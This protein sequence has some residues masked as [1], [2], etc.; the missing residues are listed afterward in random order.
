MMR[1]LF[2]SLSSVILLVSCE[3]SDNLTPTTI[4]NIEDVRNTEFSILAFKTGEVSA[5]NPVVHGNLLPTRYSN[6]AG[7]KI[8]STMNDMGS[9]C[10]LAGLS[11]SIDGGLVQVGEDRA[12]MLNIEQ[13]SDMR[14]LPEPK[15]KQLQNRSPTLSRA[16][17]C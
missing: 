4:K 3:G 17:M 14:P 9:S 7:L 13:I 12:L 8:R 10:V 16:K 6:S 11:A 5:Y 2:F 1:S 15:R